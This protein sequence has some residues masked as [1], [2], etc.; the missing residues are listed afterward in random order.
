MQHPRPFR[1]SIPVAVGVCLVLLL[2]D[3]AAR[4]NTADLFG[5]GSKNAGMGDAAVALASGPTAAFYN[6]AGLAN[7]SRPEFHFSSTAYNGWLKIRKE[8]ANI[9]NP[10][11]FAVGL[12]VAIPFKGKLAKRIWLGLLLS[13]H[14][15][16]LARVICRLP[17]EPFY[18][19]FDNRTQRM[20]L[21]TALAVRILDSR[22][23]GRLTVGLGGNVFAGLE[24]VIVGEEGASRS[25]EARVSEP[26]SGIAKLIA[27]LRY[28]WRWL[29]VG[30]AFRQ[31]FS[32]GFKTDS[33]NYVAGADLNLNV[34]SEG[35]Y[36]PHTFVGGVAFTPT[37]RI[38]VGLDF[39]YA[40]WSRYRGPYVKV[41]SVLPLV[42]ELVGDVPQVK[43]KDSV[44]VRLGGEYVVKLPKGLRMPLRLG[45]GF[46]SSPVPDQPGRTN[47]L[48]GHKI[49]LSFGGGFDLG[50]V[51]KRRVWV[52][53]HLRIHALLPRTITKKVSVAAQECPA[54]QP[55]LG[56][57]QALGDEVPCDRT[58]PSTLGVQIS[59]PG[60]PSLRASGV[61]LSGGFTLGVEL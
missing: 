42:G 38:S 9:E 51:L 61:V 2:G 40:L 41:S 5:I 15:D 12:T 35:L 8:A 24:G 50:K 11:E 30:L 32:M 36:S 25:L 60:Y 45:L 27:G 57:D 26:L 4:A 48:D 49:I 21:L 28:S 10:Y 7:G 22:K 46:E 20:V 44:A 23:N 16:I 13:A 6:P 58:D 34:D 18:P 52:D 3:G 14:P 59:N 1:H 17:T 56:P 53:M 37:D 54:Q 39:A 31:Q 33:F 47:M 29:H 43:F 19:Y 55:P